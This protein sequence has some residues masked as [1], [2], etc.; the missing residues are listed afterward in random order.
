MG[1]RSQC[2][3]VSEM[4]Q[5]VNVTMLNARSSCGIICDGGGS[6]SINGG[7]GGGCDISGGG[8]AVARQ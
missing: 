4:L 7:G 5:I 6:C 3:Q 1:G 8:G 2:L